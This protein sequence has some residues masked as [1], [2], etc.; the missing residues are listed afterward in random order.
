MA[1]RCTEFKGDIVAQDLTKIVH[2]SHCRFSN[3]KLSPRAC[4]IHDVSEKKMKELEKS[5][6]AEIRLA[7]VPAPDLRF[8]FPFDREVILCIT[9]A[10]SST[11]CR[12]DRLFASPSTRT[13][14]LSICNSL[15]FFKPTSSTEFS[16]ISMDDHDDED[17][18][19]NDD[20][21]E[22]EDNDAIVILVYL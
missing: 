12:L 5:L 11:F 13:T 6:S 14:D 17:D 22:D 3:H 10:L 18:R 4:V 9:C 15:S 21:D 16:L 20:N 2:P 19:H 1:E 7:L 8:P